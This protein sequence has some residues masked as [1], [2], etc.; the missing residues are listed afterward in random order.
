MM[1][2]YKRINMASTMLHC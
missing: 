2:M 1:N